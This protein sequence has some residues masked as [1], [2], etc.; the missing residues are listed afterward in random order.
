MCFIASNHPK[1][2]GGGTILHHMI[3]QCLAQPPL[4]EVEERS[5]GI[6]MLHVTAVAHLRQEL[7]GNLVPN[8]LL[9]VVGACR[10]VLPSFLDTLSSVVN[11]GVQ[12]ALH[13]L[14]KSC[15]W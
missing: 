4:E 15:K 14:G 2:L 5:L 10:H 1:C 13:Q 12:Q 9:Q 11:R 7:A 8:L 3:V 6:V